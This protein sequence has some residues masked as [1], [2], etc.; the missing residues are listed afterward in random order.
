MTY[1]PMSTPRGNVLFCDD[2]RMENSGKLLFIGVYTGGLVIN[3][4]FPVALPTFYAAVSYIERPGESDEPVQIV[5]RSSWDEPG[6]PIASA[7]LPVDEFRKPRPPGD[8]E[9]PQFMANVH[10]GLAPFEIKRPGE[11]I[12]YAV[13]GDKEYRLG[14]LS[15]RKAGQEELGRTDVDEP[16]RV[17]AARPSKAKRA[18]KPKV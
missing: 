7:D 16:A 5:M 18:A 12:V 10:L 3:S 4:D 8:L 13:R 1:A 9:D 11:I 14:V 15:V 6:T 17:R 2:I